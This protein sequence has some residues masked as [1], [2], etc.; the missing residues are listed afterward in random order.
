MKRI[1]MS[2]PSAAIVYNTPILSAQHNSLLSEKQKTLTV[3]RST[4]KI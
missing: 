1:I 4:A 2:V 3:V